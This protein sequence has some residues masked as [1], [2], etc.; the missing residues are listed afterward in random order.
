MFDMYSNNGLKITFEDG[1]QYCKQWYI[2][3]FFSDYVNFIQ[4]AWVAIVNY[5]VQ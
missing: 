3:Y 4:A 5:A 1:N 2:S